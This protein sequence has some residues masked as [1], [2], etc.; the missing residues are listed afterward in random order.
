[1]RRVPA[2]ADQ[3]RVRARRLLAEPPLERAEHRHA[4][5]RAT[6]SAAARAARRDRAAGSGRRA[7]AARPARSRDSTIAGDGEERRGDTTHQ[8]HRPRV[9]RGIDGERRPRSSSSSP[10]AERLRGDPRPRSTSGSRRQSVFALE[11]EGPVEDERQRGQLPPERRDTDE[12]HHG[13]RTRPISQGSTSAA[14]R[15]RTARRGR[16]AGGEQGEQPRR[17]GRGAGDRRAPPQPVIARRPVFVHR[18]AVSGQLDGAPQCRRF[19]NRPASI[20]LHGDELRH[21]GSSM[22]TP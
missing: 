1:M 14:A 15:T 16:G 12:E 20:Q 7:A 9:D 8:S 4:G 22:V 3:R 19:E 6:A 11:Q 17:A 21:P 5:A 18:K 2:D 13:E 10:S